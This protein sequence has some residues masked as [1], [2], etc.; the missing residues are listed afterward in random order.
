MQLQKQA[1]ELHVTLVFSSEVGNC[2]GGDP[3]Y[4]CHRAGWFLLR[5]VHVQL[6]PR[7]PVYP[8]SDTMELLL[9]LLPFQL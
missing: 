8:L 1:I 6:Q 5:S 2:V 9:F 3:R 7:S 4:V